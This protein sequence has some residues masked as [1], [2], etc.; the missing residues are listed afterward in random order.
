MGSGH[1]TSGRID[2]IDSTVAVDPQPIQKQQIVSIF[3]S[4]LVG[5]VL[6]T[7]P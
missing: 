5:A 6:A 7:D 2:R 3:V 1:E 4:L